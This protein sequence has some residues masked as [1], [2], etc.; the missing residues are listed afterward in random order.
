MQ[1]YKLI[2]AYD[3][4]FYAGWQIQKDKKTISFV[5]Q[6]VFF[7][8]F[9]TPC[10]LTAAS[11]TDAGVHAQGQVILCKTV[12]KIDEK[13]LL[14]A[15]NN[16]LPATILIRNLQKVTDNFHPFFNVAYKT[17]KYT[18]FTQRPLPQYAPFGWYYRYKI[19]TDVLQEIVEIFVGTHDFEKFCTTE[20]NVSTI[21]TINKITINNYDEIID[22][23]IEGKSF[24]R[25]MIRR[26]V[27]AAVAVASNQKYNKKDVLELLDNKNRSYCFEVAPACGLTL[28]KIEYYNGTR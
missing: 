26:V 15:W 10:T 13:K 22:I 12:L 3:G 27:G 7:K 14:Y 16:A 4:T 18:L 28:L 6:D 24:I 8:I 20:P 9:G 11:R 17:Y 25:H 23:F 2:I 1:K 21:R 19:N 5:M